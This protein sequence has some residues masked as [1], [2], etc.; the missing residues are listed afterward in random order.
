MDFGYWSNCKRMCLRDKSSVGSGY[1]MI[2]KITVICVGSNNSIVIM[3]EKS[4]LHI[5]KYKLKKYIPERRKK[6]ITISSS[7]FIISLFVSISMKSNLVLVM[8]INKFSMQTQLFHYKTNKPPPKKIL[9]LTAHMFKS[10]SERHFSKHFMCLI[11]FILT[12]TL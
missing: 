4:S 6:V 8:T 1:L 5:L 10:L 11:S 7:L 2:I 9:V 3:F 12:I